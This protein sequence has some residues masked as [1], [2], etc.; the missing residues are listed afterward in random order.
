MLWSAE[1]AEMNWPSFAE[2]LFAF[3]EAGMLLQEGSSHG[4]TAVAL[5]M[6][7]ISRDLGSSCRNG[8]TLVELSESGGLVLVGVLRHI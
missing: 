2:N 7:R 5:V 6:C 8:D 1:A 3:V 4:E